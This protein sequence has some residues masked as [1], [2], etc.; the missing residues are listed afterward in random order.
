MI[1]ELR[2]KIKTPT[3]LAAGVEFFKPTLVGLSGEIKH[4]V[5]FR[6]RILILGLF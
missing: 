2:R 3:V 4:L 1:E 6:I 5:F